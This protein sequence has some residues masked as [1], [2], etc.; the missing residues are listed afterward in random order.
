MASCH[1]PA[2]PAP[3]RHLPARK[4]APRRRRPPTT[5]RE[6]WTARPLAPTPAPARRP[7]P[8]ARRRPALPPMSAAGMRRA[9][10]SSALTR[11]SVPT[12][13]AVTSPTPGRA[14]CT[15][16]AGLPTRPTR[17]SGAQ[18]ARRVRRVAATF[19]HREQCPDDGLPFLRGTCAG[20]RR[21]RIPA[22][23]PA[24]GRG[25]AAEAPAP[26][27]VD[28]ARRPAAAAPQAGPCQRDPGPAALVRPT[29]RRAGRRPPRR[30]PP[31]GRPARAGQGPQHRPRRRGAAGPRRRAS[32]PRRES[33][34]ASGSASSSAVSVVPAAHSAAMAARTRTEQQCGGG[35]ARRGGQGRQRPGRG[36]RAVRSPRGAGAG[37]AG[38]RRRGPR[39]S[40]PHPCSTW[41]VDRGVP[42]TSGCRS[43]WWQRLDWA[44]GCVCVCVCVDALCNEGGPQ[45]CR[46]VGATTHWKYRSITLGT[47]SS[48][49]VSSLRCCEVLQ[50]C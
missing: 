50:W 37:P 49:M 44:E 12:A 34:A 29:V 40:F 43:R 17:F 13:R 28:P 3:L 24:A 41:A 31:A 36:L 38:E 8:A 5:A 47:R 2:P 30:R 33:R 42:H 45:V 15:T 6:G 10:L 20:C 35:V 18:R 7:R 22:P 48:G 11:P 9:R 19:E 32:P 16:P 21:R 1:A 27:A 25:A 14:T 39:H 23:G 46:P 26:V 4:S